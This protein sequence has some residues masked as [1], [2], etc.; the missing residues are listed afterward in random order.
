MALELHFWAALIFAGFIFTDRLFL[1]RA[2]DPATL[3]PLYLKARLPLAIAAS[4]LIVTGLWLLEPRFYLKAALGLA[5]IALFFA[6]PITS[7]R[8]SSKGRAL[9]RA[10]VFGLLVLTLITSRFLLF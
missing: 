6:C 10:A 4:V 2:F 3:K 1:R 5:T 8:L 9:Y 7:S